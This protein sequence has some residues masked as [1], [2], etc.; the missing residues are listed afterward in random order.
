ML[1]QFT[2]QQFLVA[3]FVLSLVW[4][5]AIFLLYYRQK[6]SGF[7]L[8]KPKEKPPEKLHK[9]WEAE[10]ED[11]PEPEEEEPGTLMGRSVEPEGVSMVAMDGVHFAE[12]SPDA[13]KDDQLGLVPDVLEEL[14]VAFR[15]LE[16]K[17]GG[18]TDFFPLIQQI[19]EKYPKIEASDNLEDINRYIRDNAPFLLTDEELEDLWD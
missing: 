9:E 5:L 3:A 8:Q 13:H 2:W 16:N 11:E 18:K 14:K 4:Y 1:E 15:D 7:F 19:K 10:L 12:R 6:A 17:D